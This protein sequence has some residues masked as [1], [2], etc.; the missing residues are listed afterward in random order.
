M[1]PIRVVICPFVTFP[2]FILIIGTVE[3]IG[4][5]V[6]AAGAEQKDPWILHGSFCFAPKKGV[7]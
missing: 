2:S 1:L 7:S 6:T 5:A 4:G 3:K